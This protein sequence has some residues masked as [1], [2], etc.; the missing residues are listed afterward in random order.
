MPVET[1]IKLPVRDLDQIRATIERDYPVRHPRTHEFNV[2][3]DSPDGSVRKKGGLLRVRRFGEEGKL[4]FKGPG[5]AGRHKQREEIEL[6]ISDGEAM[7]AILEKLGFEPVFRYEKFRTEHARPEEDGVITIDETPI[8]YFLELEGPAEWIDKAA[9]QL[10]YAEADY[11]TESY[12]SLYADYRRRTGTSSGD[13]LFEPK[14]N[15]GNN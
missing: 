13:M 7:A 10:G 11:I 3:F 4:T 14:A 6:K 2:L 15:A 9:E 8:G 1:E 12:G 5:A